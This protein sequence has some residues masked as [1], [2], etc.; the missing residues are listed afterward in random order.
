MPWNDVVP[1]LKAL[2]KAVQSVQVFAE[3]EAMAV[4]VEAK[5][6]VRMVGRKFTLTSAVATI[7]NI[8]KAFTQWLACTVDIHAGTRYL[9]AFSSTNPLDVKY[10][11]TEYNWPR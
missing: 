9:N 8:W 6:K 10:Y 5:I 4:K 7:N 3:A 2:T 11:A 1:S